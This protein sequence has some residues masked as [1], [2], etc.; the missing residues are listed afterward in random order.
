MASQN[1]L[2]VAQRGFA[3]AR[4][5]LELM[6]DLVSSGWS[7]S[8]AGQADEY[9]PEIERIGASFFPVPTSV[10]GATATYTRLGRSLR[11]GLVHI[12]NARPV[13][14]AT[15]LLK[16]STR[17]A[18]VCTITGLGQ[19]FEATWPASAGVRAGYR[20]AT[21]MADAV[22]FQNRDDARELG[23]DLAHR[24][25]HL[26]AGSGVDLERFRPTVRTRQGTPS[27]L[28][29]SRLLWSKGILEYVS[30]A[31]AI[32]E[33]SP[34]VRFVLAGEVVESEADGMTR[35]WIE[36]ELPRFSVDYVGRI[37]DIEE[38][39]P[40]FDILVHPSYYR[41]GVPRILLEAGASGVPAIA[42]DVP[43]SQEVLVNGENG[44]MVPPQSVEALQN[45][46][47]MLLSDEALRR[48]MGVRARA[49]AEARFGVSSVTRRTLDIYAQ[50]GL[51]DPQ[52]SS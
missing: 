29:A 19:A 24:R 6:A 2:F 5:R 50:L 10:A 12:F 17:A 47:E 28:M 20:A 9:V 38:R 43:S 42:A 4:S 41:E 16:V 49:I 48:D 45:A 27:V 52:E 23:C 18:I 3:L 25:Y 11:P 1:A 7:V 44:F 14:L 33:H 39:L 32:T 46:I 26:I 34:K 15:P 8:A 35:R 40:R 30:A 13:L 36:Q 37:D 51:V 21:R 31:A 22:I